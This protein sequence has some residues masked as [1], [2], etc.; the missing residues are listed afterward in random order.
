[1]NIAKREQVKEHNERYVAEKKR[2]ADLAANP[3]PKRVAKRRGDLLSKM[4]VTAAV[5]SMS[6]VK[7][8]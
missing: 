3:R 4:L 5:M 6:Q 8:K 2:I 7:D 1:M